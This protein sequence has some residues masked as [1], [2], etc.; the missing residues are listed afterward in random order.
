VVSDP[1]NK[2]A[3]SLGFPTTPSADA[4]A[5]LMKLGVDVKALN[6]DGTTTLPMPTVLV[7]DGD[8]TLR[9][10]DIHPDYTTRTEV[11]DIVAALYT[12]G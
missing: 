8:H 11:A 4:L 10:I 12:L 1:G 5:S 3:S 6:A 2:L 9:W 7:I